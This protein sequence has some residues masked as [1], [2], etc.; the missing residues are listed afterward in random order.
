MAK[1]VSPQHQRDFGHAHGHARM[2]GVGLLHG[3]DREHT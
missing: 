2:P 3:I 1:M